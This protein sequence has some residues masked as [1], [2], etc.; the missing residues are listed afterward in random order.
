MKHLLHLAKRAWTSIDNRPIPYQH[1]EK[2]ERILTPDEFMWWWKL[3]PRD[4]AHSIVVYERF[5]KLIPYAKRDEQAA[6][7]LHDIGKLESSLGWT[8]RVVATIVGPRGKR[9][10]SYH[11]HETIAVEML[12]SVCSERTLAM[13]R[14]EVEE[15]YVSA[16]READNI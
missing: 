14:G 1:V 5:M 11:N 15:L 16:L 8:M 7:L 2:V 12:S 4:Q 9:F 13:L 6:V 3:E 10:S